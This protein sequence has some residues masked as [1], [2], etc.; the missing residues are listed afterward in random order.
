[1][2][3][4]YILPGK[5]VCDP[6]G[7]WA[8]CFPPHSSCVVMRAGRMGRVFNRERL[9]SVTLLNT[10]VFLEP[11]AGIAAGLHDRLEEEPERHQAMRQFSCIFLLLMGLWSPLLSQQYCSFCTWL[12]TS[13]PCKHHLRSALGIVSQSQGR[14]SDWYVRPVYHGYGG[15]TER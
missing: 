12:K 8:I 15:V 1:M 13:S 11:K 10:G 4:H 5:P 6:L 2:E 7:Y 3:Q 14:E 9:T